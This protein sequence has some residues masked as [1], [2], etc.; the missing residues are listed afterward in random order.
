MQ[1]IKLNDGH[2]TFKGRVYGSV[3]IEYRIEYDKTAFRMEYNYKYVH[4]KE[5]RDMLDG[6][7]D[8][9]VTYELTPLKKGQF[10][11]YEVEGFRGQETARKKHTIVVI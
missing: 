10:D 7:D 2:L 9:T 8:S 1:V 11:I 5:D 3:G 6:A 4:S